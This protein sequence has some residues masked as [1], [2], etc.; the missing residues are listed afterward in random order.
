MYYGGVIKTE[1]TKMNYYLVT[2]KCGHVG[3]TSYMPIT[4]PVI[5]ESGKEAARIVRGYPRVKRDHWDAIL[6]CQKVDEATHNAQKALNAKDP[7]LHATSKQ[8][9]DEMV[10][11]L[12][13]RIES[14]NHQNELKKLN[15]KSSK[16]NLMFQRKKYNGYRYEYEYE[17]ALSY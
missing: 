7:Y 2:A 5:A 17:Y 4:F 9:Q 1:V 11:N 10:T 8:E 12:L 6:D 13:E 15:K 14:D 3:K 16:P